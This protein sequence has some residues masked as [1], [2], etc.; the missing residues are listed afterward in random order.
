MFCLQVV[1]LKL[2]C[3]RLCLGGG[4]TKDIDDITSD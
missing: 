3:I 2:T 4:Y 1:I